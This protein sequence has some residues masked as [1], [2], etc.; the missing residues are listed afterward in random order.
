[1]VGSGAGW[2]P[3]AEAASII[4]S[5]ADTGVEPSVTES[6]YRSNRGVPVREKESKDG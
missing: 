3:Y 4:L 1:M 2:L 5:T 6:R